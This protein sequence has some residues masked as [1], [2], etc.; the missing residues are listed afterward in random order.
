[1][2]LV[3]CRPRRTNAGVHE[4]TPPIDVASVGSG[5]CSVEQDEYDE[6]ALVVG[7]IRTEL[8]EERERHAHALETIHEHERT[9]S[10]LNSKIDML[11]AQIRAANRKPVARHKYPVGGLGAIDTPRDE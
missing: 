11:N 6:Y 7:A 4:E 5:L 2:G 9:I 8:D 3:L 1:M 10:Q